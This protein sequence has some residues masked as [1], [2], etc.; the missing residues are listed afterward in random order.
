MPMLPLPE[1]LEQVRVALLDESS[2]VRASASGARRATSP[3]WK[4]IELRPVQLKAG[5][6][7]QL[8]TYDERQAFTSNLEPGQEAERR[9]AELVQQPFATWRVETVAETLQLRVTKK[10]EGQLSRARSAGTAVTP[11]G[12]D[13][14]ARHL[15][16]PDDPLFTVLGAGAAKRRQVDAFLRH[17]EAVVPELGDGPLQVV[18]LGCGNAYLS[19]AVHRFLSRDRQVSLLGVDEKEQSREH[20]TAVAE[21]LGIADSVRFVA[22]SIEQAPLD[23]PDLVLALHACDTASDDALARAVRAQAQVILVAP[24]CHHDLQRQVKAGETPAPYALL[25]RHGILRERFTDVLT[26]A[27]RAALLRLLGYRVEVVEFVSAE[28][29]PRNVLLRAVRTG[30]PAPP[31]QVRDY[32]D[33]VA[34]WQVRPALATRLEPELSAILDMS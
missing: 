33:L 13:R 8:V 4:R 28:Q 1:A 10:G 7:L 3:D 20:G 25:T 15:L 16:A 18:D 17:V 22:S 27:L 34:E 9:V 14:E 6:R 11:L 29:T 31:D 2:L 30:A 21:S 19:F 26:D 24:C 5:R 23:R 32:L 12:N